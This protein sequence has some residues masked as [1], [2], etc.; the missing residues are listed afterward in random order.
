M[1]LS[2]SHSG[3][4]WTRFALERWNIGR[5]ALKI[6]TS[7]QKYS[8]ITVLG[9]AGSPILSSFSL[10]F[11]NDKTL[12]VTAPSI[13]EYF[14]LCTEFS[15]HWSTFAN[16]LTSEFHIHQ[17]EYLTL[18]NSNISFEPYSVI[19]YVAPMFVLVCCV[20]VSMLWQL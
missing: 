9:T 7:V 20:S 4:G 18:K 5:F 11:Q 8:S 1:Y 14:A 6:P 15:W 3:A 10:R 12:A 16:L 2:T 17:F 13:T 19:L